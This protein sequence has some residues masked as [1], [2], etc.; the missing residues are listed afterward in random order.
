[1]ANDGESSCHQPAPSAVDPLDVASEQELGVAEVAEQR[2]N[3]LRL[4]TYTAL[5]ILR[6][7]HFFVSSK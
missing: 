1:M 6:I 4:V 2:A 7:D 5:A 3:V